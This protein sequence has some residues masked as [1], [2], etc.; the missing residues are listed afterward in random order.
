M[1]TAISPYCH[2]TAPEDRRVAIDLNE[3]KYAPLASCKQ[4]SGCN[5][6]RS[7]RHLGRARHGS[8][9]PHI[10][11]KPIFGSGL[12]KNGQLA[13]NTLV[14]FQGKFR[15]AG[16]GRPVQSHITGLGIEAED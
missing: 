9:A 4:L 6:D 3:S 14:K 13:V 12:A 1:E 7:L 10:L 8:I 2:P 5:R 15:V 11:E 16:S